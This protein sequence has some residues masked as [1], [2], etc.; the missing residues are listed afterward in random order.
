MQTKLFEEEEIIVD[1]TGK[2]CFNPVLRSMFD[3]QQ[4]F[5]ENKKVLCDQLQQDPEYI[6]NRRNKK[7]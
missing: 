7:C 1:K 2:T 6:K 4:A 5:M 3:E